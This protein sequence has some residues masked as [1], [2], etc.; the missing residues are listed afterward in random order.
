MSAVIS[1]E[2][3][4]RIAFWA[5]AA[6]ALLISHD[7]TFLVQVG[8]GEALARA[9][10]EAGHGYW[11]AASA[12][13]LL[14]G[15]V[16]GARIGIRLFQLRRRASA[17]DAQAPAVPRTVWL[18]R[19]ATNWGRLLLLVSIGF[20]VQENVEHVLSHGH[21][22]GLGALAG[23]ESPLA[24]PVIAAI[25]LVAALLATAVRV[26]ERRLVEGI[27]AALRRPLGRAPRSVPRPAPRIL[28]RLSSP[29]ARAIAGR[30]PP[31]FLVAT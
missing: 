21:A 22:P 19:A 2:R 12:V 17:L 25:T 26:A 28:V 30:A 8:P 24:L 6:L 18:R 7:A 31:S 4:P 20:L 15:L 10:R 9:L 11:G 27:L 16:A 29:I 23:P 5:L 13:L 1:D 14:I 3:R